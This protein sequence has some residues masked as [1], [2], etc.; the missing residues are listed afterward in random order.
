[1]LSE[2]KEFIAKGNVMDLAVGVIIGAAFQRIVDSLVTDVLMPVVGLATGGAD[3]TNMFSVLREGTKVAGPYA[4]LAEAKAAGANVIA[5]GAFVNQIIQFL[6]LAWVV[7]LIVKAF[8][9]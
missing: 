4:S 3:F 1:M 8:N 2:F 6:I 9:R 7:F 5:W